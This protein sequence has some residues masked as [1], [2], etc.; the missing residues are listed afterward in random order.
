MTKK[1]MFAHIAIV[2]ADNAEIVDFCNHE[3]ELLEGRK[4]SGSKKKVAETEARA[5]NVYD[6]LCTFDSAVTV[7]EIIANA[8]NEVAEYT[9]QRVSALLRKLIADGRVEKTIEGKKALFRVVA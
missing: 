6:V 2:N 7:T 8:T 4:T 9:N 5:E 1:E 3:I